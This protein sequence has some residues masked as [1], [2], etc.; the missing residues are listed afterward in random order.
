MSNVN[1]SISVGA[2]VP[3][4]VRLYP[5]PST[6]IS[7]VPQYRGYDYF[8]VRDEIIIVEPRTKKI[9]TVISSSNRAAS[10]AT[11]ER[12]KFSDQERAVIRKKHSSS[13]TGAGTRTSVTVGQRVPDNVELRS[14]DEEVYRAVPTVRTYRYIDGPSGVYLVDPTERTV[15]EEID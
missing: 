9:V 6:V 14:F 2:A 7:I 3:S 12:V 15:I 10:T 11:R 1:F 5:L 8:V 13:T 4:H